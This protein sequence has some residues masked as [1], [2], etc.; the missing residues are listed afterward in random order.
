MKNILSYIPGYRTKKVWK[1][2]IASIYYAFSLLMILG[3]FGAF[4]FFAA[5]P[6]VVFSFANAIRCKAPK[7]LIVTLIGFILMIIGLEWMPDSSSQPE[8]AASPVPT[9][10]ATK[11]PSALPSSSPTPTPT[12]APTSAPTHAPTAEPTSAPTPASTPGSTQQPAETE[13]PVEAETNSNTSSSHSESS[14][15]SNDTEMV[16]VGETGTKYHYK[17]CRSLRGK[18]RQITMEEAIAEGRTSC[19]ICHR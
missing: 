16:W 15:S 10:S 19:G 3:G 13:P 11:A 14:E 9:V 5:A 4:L 2:I 18:G 17:G 6:F 12:S 1:M 8:P 7:R